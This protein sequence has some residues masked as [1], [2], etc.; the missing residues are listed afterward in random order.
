MAGLSDFRTKAMLGLKTCMR[1]SKAV[2]RLSDEK[3]QDAFDY[4]LTTGVIVVVVASAWFVF[5]QLVP[6]VVGHACPSV[7]TAASPA[8]TN[9]SCV[10]T[11]P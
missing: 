2:I 8:A 4:L 6:Q 7:D 10:T 11:T 5:F 1:S 9:D 3:A